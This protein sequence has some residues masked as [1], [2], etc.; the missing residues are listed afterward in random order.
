MSTHL[1]HTIGAG[2]GNGVRRPERVTR[3]ASGVTP[4]RSEPL[5]IAVRTV[6]RSPFPVRR[7]PFAA[8][9]RRP[10]PALYP[11][12]IQTAIAPQRRSGA[13]NSAGIS[14]IPR[15]TS[16]ASIASIRSVPS[17]SVS[18]SLRPG[19]STRCPSRNQPT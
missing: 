11:F 8:A 4:P 10:P 15:N 17:P 3:C 5:A 1:A 6:P 16:T 19:R 9:A 2:E 12:F 14:E 7:S 13:A 18:G